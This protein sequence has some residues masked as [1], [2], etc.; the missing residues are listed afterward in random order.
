MALI[1]TFMVPRWF[2]LQFISLRQLIGAR[3]TPP[4]AAVEEEPLRDGR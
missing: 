3:S 1:P 2:L 4:D